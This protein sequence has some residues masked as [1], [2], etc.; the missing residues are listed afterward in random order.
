MER[1]FGLLGSGQS[2]DS[3]RVGLAVENDTLTATEAGGASWK[4]PLTRVH[5]V[6]WA[7]DELRLELAGTEVSF[8]PEEPDAALAHLLPALLARQE[9]GAALAG[10]AAAGGTVAPFAPEISDLTVD[11]TKELRPPTPTAGVATFGGPEL[12]ADG[13]VR[14]FARRRAATA[15]QIAPPVRSRRRWYWWFV[16]AA[17]VLGASL[18]TQLGGSEDPAVAARR[19]I[20]DGGLPTVTVAVDDG[21]ATLSGSTPSQGIADAIAGVVATVDGVDVVNS[22]LLVSVPTPTTIPGT[23]PDLS[24]AARTAL[25]GAGLATTEVSVDSG[26]AVLTGAVASEFERRSAVSAVS[27]VEGVGQIDN[28]L[29]VTSLPDDTIQSATR[30]ALDTGGFND[31]AV[32]IQ[33]GVAVVAGTV[34][35]EV[36]GGGF[37]RYSDEV[38]DAVLRIAGVAG[39]TN[40]L[41]LAGD[42]A[43]L[44]RQLRELTDGSPVVFAL[45]RADLSPAA[46]TTLDAAAVIIQAQPGLRVLIAGHTD[47]TGSAVRN[48]ELSG[49][50]AQAVRSYLIEQGI[51]ANR[52]LIVAYG[53]LFSTT[54]GSQQGD[55]RVEFEVAG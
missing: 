22:N 1:C 36:L 51:A 12:A 49:L 18:A 28:Q 24:V 39:L 48:E 42:E 11:L 21:T 19:A 43:T 17:M 31:I 2:P 38:E 9:R 10:A 46:A 33:D 40:R 35:P 55:R 13:E 5:L 37:F 3:K 29:L 6:G 50:R 41:Q 14:S 53:E 52:L 54:P 8:V 34:P 44:R 20:A 32:S 47:T 25:A 7:D 4:I 23:A 15:A 27:T 45:G 26:V 16:A 30:E